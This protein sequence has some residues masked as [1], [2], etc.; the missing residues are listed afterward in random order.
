MGTPGLGLVS[1]AK[2]P[3]MSVFE[4]GAGLFGLAYAEY[5]TSVPKKLA[6]PF[7]PVTIWISVW[8]GGEQ[9]A[10]VVT[11]PGM[12]VGD[13]VTNA[14]T[15]VGEGVGVGVTRGVASGVIDGVAVAV[16]GWLGAA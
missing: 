12:D 4:P 8:P 16:P 14:D 1:M 13:G 5:S 6:C 15:T 2:W 7:G 3:T 9:Y 11:T 10:A